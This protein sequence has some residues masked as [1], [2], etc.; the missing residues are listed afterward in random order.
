M[1]CAPLRGVEVNASQMKQGRR[2]HKDSNPIVPPNAR[3]Y[4]WRE[5]FSGSKFRCLVGRYSKG[6]DYWKSTVCPIIDH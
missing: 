1:E 5:Y 3:I 4:D 6:S 2:A